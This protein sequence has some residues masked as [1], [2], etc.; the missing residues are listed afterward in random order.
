MEFYSKESMLEA[1]DDLTIYKDEYG[2]ISKLI[3]ELDGTLFTRILEEILNRNISFS[4]FIQLFP[5][6]E[7]KNLL[8][9]NLENEKRLKERVDRYNEFKQRVDAYSYVEFRDNNMI[10]ADSQDSHELY[11]QEVNNLRDNILYSLFDGINSDPPLVQASKKALIQYIKEDK[12]L[13]D[14]SGVIEYNRVTNLSQTLK[15]YETSAHLVTLENKGNEVIPSGTKFYI[16]DKK[17]VVT[18]RYTN[19][20]FL[21]GPYESLSAIGMNIYEN[22]ARALT[23][24]TRNLEPRDIL[25]KILLFAEKEMIPLETEYQY[26]NK[27]DTN[28]ML[29][30]NL[31]EEQMKKMKALA[32]FI[33]KKELE[34]NINAEE[35]TG[36]GTNV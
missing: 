12:F 25:N 2:I 20:Y 33:R 3:D 24:K 6:N 15:V 19:S 35:V 13:S 23:I 11:T 9:Y 8:V 22:Q 4:D 5:A 28:F 27:T 29:E 26:L 1:I 30:N 14:S 32:T 17:M 18:E 16:S 34:F 31:T 7:Y 10:A 21:S 36:D